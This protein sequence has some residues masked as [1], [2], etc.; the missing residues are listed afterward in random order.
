[1]CWSDS[2]SWA[3][4]GRSGSPSGGRRRRRRRAPRRVAGRDPPDRPRLRRQPADQGPRRAPP[5]GDKRASTHSDLSFPSAH[6]TTSFCAAR[7]YARLGLPLYPLAFALAASRVALRVH[8]PPTSSPAPRW[9][10][11]SPDEG[12]HRRPAQR[13]QVLAVQ[14][15][16]AGR[17]P[18][19]PT[20]RSRRSS[21][22]WRSSRRRRPPRARRRDRRLLRDRLGHD[23]LPRHRGLVRG[24]SEGEGLG[25]KFLANIRETDA[26]VHVVR[27]HGDTGVIHRRARSTRCAT[28]RSSRPSSSSPTSSRPS[29]ATSASCATPAAA[30]AP[31]SPRRPGSGRSSPRCSAGS[32]SAP[33]RCPRRRPTPR[34]TSARSPPSRPVRR[35]RRRGRRR[36]AEV[37]A[38]HAAAQGAVAV[39]VS[40]RLEAELSELEE[41]DAAAMRADLGVAESGLQRVVHGAFALLDLIAFFTAG[42]AKPAQSWHLK[43]AGPPGT[44]P[45]RSTPTSR[46][47]RP[48]RGHRLGRAGRRGRL[49]RRARPR[50]AA[51]RGPRLR[52]GRRRRDHREVHALTG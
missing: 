12:R 35:Q 43:R 21:R 40:S 33:C 29:A 31:R 28:S 48:R 1:M 46:R 41:E 14:R 16:H 19:R 50:D 6:A 13:G 45:A 8:H 4:T 47:V 7:L 15:A 20:T 5:A 37:V 18:R 27:A 22:T 34:A 32:R 51:P 49:R 24:A 36:G 30:T 38:A 3:S 44:P 42:E 9:G 17:A 11:C 52:H 23:R 26:I 39:A 2:R 10:R 25:N